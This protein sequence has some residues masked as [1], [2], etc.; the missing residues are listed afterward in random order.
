MCGEG[1]GTLV[2]SE[3]GTRLLTTLQERFTGMEGLAVID[4]ETGEVMP[5]R[6]DLGTVSLLQPTWP[7]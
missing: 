5:V 1:G 7:G 3:D 2:W 4:V 6:Q